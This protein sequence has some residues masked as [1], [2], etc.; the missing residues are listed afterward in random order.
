MIQLALYC[1]E[2]TL[3]LAELSCGSH[4]AMHGIPA[5]LNYPWQAH[6]SASHNLFV[7]LL[8]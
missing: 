6:I 4:S 7:T 1:I 8:Q 2:A 5:L 3:R